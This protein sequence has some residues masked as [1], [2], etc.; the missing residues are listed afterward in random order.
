MGIDLTIMT[1]LSEHRSPVFDLLTGAVM[2]VGTSWIIVALV[3]VIGLAFVLR[4]RR[5]TVGWSVVMAVAC[6][7]VLAQILK[8]LV[9]RPRPPLQLALVHT[10]GWAMPSSHAILTSAVAL[11]AFLAFEWGTGRLRRIVGLALAGAV[12]LVGLSMVYLGV[13]WPSDVI[14]GWV[15]GSIVGWISFRVA[16]VFHPGAEAPGKP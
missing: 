7:V 2:K 15:L 11:A 12:V 3:A 14:V 9:Q 13:H 16:S 1:Y 8:S 10:S 5:W 6:S 4:T